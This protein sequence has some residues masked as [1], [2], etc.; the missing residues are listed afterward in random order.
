MWCYDNDTVE[1][2][3]EDILDQDVEKKHSRL[4]KIDFIRDTY[5]L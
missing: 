4:V 3:L 2:V 1:K 5:S